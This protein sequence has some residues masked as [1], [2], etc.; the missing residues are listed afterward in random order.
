MI[1]I[2][3]LESESMLSTGEPSWYMPTPEY[4]FLPSSLLYSQLKVQVYS[5]LWR[6]LDNIHDR[7]GET[8][9][10]AKQL[11]ASTWIFS[12]VRLKYKPTH[13]GDK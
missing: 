5:S 7:S 6:G 13:S 9:I 4:R 12:I 8:P 2:L 11:S 10:T 3:G 1:A